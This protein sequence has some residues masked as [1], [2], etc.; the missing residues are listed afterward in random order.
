MKKRVI[1]I[2][3]GVVLLFIGIFLTGK[4]FLVNQNDVAAKKL[5]IPTQEEI[6]QNGYPINENGQTYGPCVGDFIPDLMLAKNEE[7]MLGYIYSVKTEVS[8]PEEAMEYMKNGDKNQSSTMYLQ[9]GTTVIGTFFH[10][11]GSVEYY[12]E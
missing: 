3:F 1:L 8:S 6:L 7:G 5:L 11:I 12:I 4:T 9:D 2:V 10:G